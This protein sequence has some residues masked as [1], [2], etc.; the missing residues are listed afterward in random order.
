MVPVTPSNTYEIR[1]YVLS[2]VLQSAEGDSLK[3]AFLAYLGLLPAGITQQ[4]A[5][6]VYLRCAISGMIA[7]NK[8]CEELARLLGQSSFM[9]GTPMPWVGDIW[10]VLGIKWAVDHAADPATASKFAGWVNEF[11]PQRIRDGRLTPHERTIAEYILSNELSIA[12]ASCV[13]LFL[14]YKDILPIQ[15]PEQKKKFLEEFF[16]DFRDAYKLQYSPLIL[17][18]FI[19]VFDAVNA[20]VAALPPNLWGEQEII[21]F[22]ENIPAGLKRWTWEASPR[23]KNSSAVKWHLEN[24]Y[25]VQNLLYVML[26]PIFPDV[27]D[28]VYTDP[29]GQKNPRLDLYLPSIDTVIEVKYR[30]DT[31][32]SFQDLIGEVAEDASL[33]R[34][35]TKFK[36]SKLIVFLWD[37][38]RAT[39]E[40]VKFKEGVMRID[41]INGCVVVCSPSVME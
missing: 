13:A 39:Q 32:K 24:E 41:G 20:E 17:A 14:H 30:K 8:N 16:E 19:Y 6:K 26:A 12:S 1:G 21:K 18:L 15:E 27:S 9:D 22:L 2:S 4:P 40:H 23:T 11:L 5:D 37:H 29:V 25:H 28:E 10:A 31:K 34:A 3:Q 35:D 7:E 33:Y 36:K 38:T